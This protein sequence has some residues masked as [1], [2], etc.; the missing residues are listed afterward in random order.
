MTPDVPIIDLKLPSVPTKESIVI[1]NQISQKN[2]KEA[3]KYISYLNQFELIEKED[4][5]G[6]P[7]E[8]QVSPLKEDNSS[9][10]FNAD[11][12]MKKIKI[13]KI[14]KVKGKGKDFHQRNISQLYSDVKEEIPYQEKE[15]KQ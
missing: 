3:Q 12:Q 11:E 1:S 9:S 8:E 5:G 6:V 14:G 4:F 2:N 7:N 13:R 10:T 15:E